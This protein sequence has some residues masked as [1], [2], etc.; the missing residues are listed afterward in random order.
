MRPDA[1]VGLAF[2]L[3]ALGCRPAGDQRTETLTAEEAR[4]A[5]AALSPEVAALI[6]SGNAAYRERRDEAA[7]RHFGAAVQLDST[8]AAAWFGVYMAEQRLGNTDAAEAALRR[9]RRAEPGA[10]LIEPPAA[11]RR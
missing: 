9:A 1:L 7:L 11:G 4:A 2:A 6:D 5:R 10:S 8:L 3:V